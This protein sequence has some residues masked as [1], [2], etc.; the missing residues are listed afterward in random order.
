MKKF[1]SQQELQEIRERLS[2]SIA[3]K[4]LPENASKVDKVKYKFCE[5]FIIYKNNNQITQRVLAEKIGINESLVRKITHYH[6]EEFTIDCLINYL[7]KIFPNFEID[8]ID[9]L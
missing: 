1:P 3:S 8:I 4:P 2:V 9:A 5:Q 7:D 6:F